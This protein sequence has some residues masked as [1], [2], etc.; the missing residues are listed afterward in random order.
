MACLLR[1][2]EARPI[3]HHIFTPNTPRRLYATENRAFVQTAGSLPHLCEI[4]DDHVS[5]IDEF[6]GLGLRFVTAG[7]ANRLAVVTDGGDA[8]L[9]HRNAPIELIDLDE[10]VEMVGIGSRFEIVVTQ[11]SVW[12]RG[13]SKFWSVS[14]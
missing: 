9:P 3:T 13:Q 14:C 5:I 10:P 1:N 7:T 4:I 2:E 11:Q 8:Y 12:V 6:E